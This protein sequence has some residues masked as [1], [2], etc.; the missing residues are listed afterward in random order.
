[1]N[2]TQATV[3]GGGLAGCEAAWQLAERG[4]RVSLIEMKPEKKSPAHHSDSLAELVCSNSF[5]GDK[6]SNAVGLLKEEMRRFGS[7]IMKCADATR[8]P[9]GGA[10]AVDRDLFSRQVTQAVC[11]HPGIR[12]VR[13]EAKKIPDGPVIIATGPLTSEDFSKE[14][15]SLPG[16]SFLNFY[17]AAAPIVLRESLDESKLYRL[18]RY[19]RGSDYLNA[20]MNEEQYT[21]FIL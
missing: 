2:D 12:L 6:L 18:S 4:I 1:M 13:E 9:A 21:K 5:R 17:D 10:L 11:S 14:I 3:I 8:V 19:N 15:S 16:L 7:L 20:P